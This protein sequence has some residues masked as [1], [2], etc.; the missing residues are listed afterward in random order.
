M[1]RL[2]RQLAVLPIAIATGCGS[3][4]GGSDAARAIDPNDTE[5]RIDCVGML[6]SQFIRNHYSMTTPVRVYGDDRLTLSGCSGVLP[7][8]L[9]GPL[10]LSV[11]PTIDNLD[12]QS[13]GSLSLRFNGEWWTGESGSIKIDSRSDWKGEG[14][15]EM[16]VF[17]D[18][19]RNRKATARGRFSYCEYSRADDCPIRPAATSLSKRV[20]IH[21][22]DVIRGEGEPV[23]C[24]ALH[25]PG[26]GA[27]QVDMEL[28]TWLGER[29]TDLYQES[30]PG[31]GGFFEFPFDFRFR[32]GGVS[33]PGEYGPQRVTESNGTR[34]PEVR[35]NLPHVL[36]PGSADIGDLVC[37][38]LGDRIQYQ[39]VYDTQCSFGLTND[40]FS[41]V[42]DPTFGR[43]PRGIVSF[44][45]TRPLFI[46]A[47]CDYREVD[48]TAAAG[49]PLLTGSLPTSVNAGETY[50]VDLD[51]IFQPADGT[52]LWYEW[53]IDATI[54]WG[55][56]NPEDVTFTVAD[57]GAPG[58]P[59]ANLLSL[60]I[61]AATPPQNPGRLAID[62]T[63]HGPSAVTTISGSV[64]VLAEPAVGAEAL[65]PFSFTAIPAGTTF[66]LNPAWRQTPPMA[67]F[68]IECAASNPN[69]G[70]TVAKAAG[71]PRFTI[72][73]AAPAG[74]RLALEI[75]SA[76]GSVWT[77]VHEFDVAAPV[78]V[79][80]PSLGAPTIV[81]SKTSSAQACSV[82]A[83]ANFAGSNHP[84]L[85]IHCFG[86]VG[87]A[88]GDGT[89][90]APLVEVVRT[91]GGGP[92]DGSVFPIGL[93][94]GRYGFVHAS[95]DTGRQP[96][97][98][99]YQA[100]LNADLDGDGV[101]NTTDGCILTPDPLQP[102][103]DGD[104]VTDACDIVGYPIDLPRDNTLLVQS[105]PSN[106]ALAI[107]SLAPPGVLVATLPGLAPTG[108]LVDPTLEL[109]A[110]FGNDGDLDAVTSTGLR[111][112]VG[113]T[114]MDVSSSAAVSSLVTPDWRVASA[115]AGEAN[116][117][118][119][120][121]PAFPSL[122][123]RPADAQVDGWFE[124]TVIPEPPC[125]SACVPRSFADT[126]GDG[127][128]EAAH[129]CVSNRTEVCVLEF[130][131]DGIP[132]DAR[133]VP[134]GGAGLVV[135]TDYVDL[136]LDGKLD[137][138]AAT[139]ADAT[140]QFGQ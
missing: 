61:P 7:S 117:V 138:I 136:D 53:S 122:H 90:F 14:T 129:F 81:W 139:Q 39:E 8:L 88:L 101:P 65:H 75:G 92:P 131:P 63:A 45:S 58:G 17:S 4:G 85:L 116:V 76:G 64:S 108:T 55:G 47:D 99:A 110:D 97:F 29:V 86:V 94:G 2:A 42:C 87:I 46:D 69:C 44:A 132:S 37:G 82:V 111:K 77:L 6:P 130:S 120:G 18:F 102:D 27:L 56:P 34:L 107:T 83:A 60:V 13:S 115:G 1:S 54:P 95:S 137:T 38:I 127:A 79:P 126:D 52:P 11:D 3:G 49:R 22:P 20:S 121:N 80:T 51:T 21:V 15:Y 25:D 28:G 93:S 24:R 35:M 125:P 109:L 31:G 135:F 124:L 103:A 119:T 91:R 50:S 84:D 41:L 70:V 32:A 43:D 118:L 12:S 5:F 104:G 66:L 106:P 59:R 105:A 100:T 57:T 72:P 26:T 33:G 133:M 62:V 9:D 67:P 134:N 112:L 73:D 23:V 78:V 113:G 114:L 40:H 30:C 98:V 68:R 74:T 89:S 123:W 10:E 96:V 71:E 19:D 36:L 128:L 48:P 16:Q 140:A